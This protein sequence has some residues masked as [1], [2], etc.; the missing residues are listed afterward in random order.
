MISDPAQTR[1]GHVVHDLVF[2]LVEFPIFSYPMLD[3]FKK[4]SCDGQTAINS[5]L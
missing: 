1:T 4:K 2:F 5:V 3:L